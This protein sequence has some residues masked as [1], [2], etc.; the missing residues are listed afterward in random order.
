MVELLLTLT[1]APVDDYSLAGYAQ[2]AQAARRA[3]AQQR[4]AAAAAARQGSPGAAPAATP[5]PPPPPGPESMSVDGGAG[6]SGAG[7]GS[8][9]SDVE[10]DGASASWVAPTSAPSVTSLPED[11]EMGGDGAQDGGGAGGGAAAGGQGPHV[12]FE[13]QHRKLLLQQP[14][15]S[16]T[17]SLAGKR[18]FRDAALGDA[19]LLQ[20]RGVAAPVHADARVVA[21]RRSAGPPRSHAYEGALVGAGASA[22]VWTP[23]EGRSPAHERVRACLAA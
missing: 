22:S 16:A 19:A 13:L 10:D 3:Q 4:A 9:A 14:F 21:A 2:R 11:E 8:G 17:W 6:A 1:P 7:A 15:D 23:H 18:K 20:V 12:V 5:P